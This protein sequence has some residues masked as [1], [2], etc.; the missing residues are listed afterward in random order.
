MYSFYMNWPV[1]RSCQSEDLSFFT[2]S[3]SALPPEVT[4]E[5]SLH[6]LYLSGLGGLIGLIRLIIFIGLI[7]D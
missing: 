3:L 7:T 4:S 5:M 6:F 1:G 2:F